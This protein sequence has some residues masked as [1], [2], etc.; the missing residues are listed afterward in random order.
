MNA[1]STRYI[2]TAVLS[3][4]VNPARFSACTTGG[5]VPRRLQDMHESETTT[6]AVP[7]DICTCDAYD[8]E[9]NAC[10]EVS[11]FVFFW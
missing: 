4:N 2:Y 8:K 5:V 1:L 11:R 6:A 3:L 7:L 9:N 10:C